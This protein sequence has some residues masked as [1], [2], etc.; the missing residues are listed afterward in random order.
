MT[1]LQVKLQYKKTHAEDW[2]QVEDKALRKKIQNRLAKRKS[3]AAAFKVRPHQKRT[4]S[5]GMLR[6]SKSAARDPT[7]ISLPNGKNGISLSSHGMGGFGHV[8]AW[9]EPNLTAFGLFEYR[10]IHLTQY[11]LLRAFLQ[12][13]SILHLEPHVFADDNALSPW[14]VSNPYRTLTPPMLSPTPLQLRTPH[15]PYLDV[16]APPRL[17]D[18]ILMARLTDEEEEIVCYAIHSDSFTVW[19]EQPWN[20]MGWEMSQSFTNDW[21]W[22]LDEETIQYSNFWRAERG[23][24]PLVMPGT[25]LTVLEGAF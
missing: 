4:E 25:G 12:N 6:H 16:I 5:S 8:G 13:A 17:R 2:T 21:A 20:A 14:T 18:N 3:R 11:S 19:G 15:H 7:T 24:P 9:M 22:L 23:E 1:D 10:F